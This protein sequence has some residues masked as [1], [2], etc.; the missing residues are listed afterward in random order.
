M[1]K[2]L[3]FEDNQLFRTSAEDFLHLH[4]FQVKSL[5]CFDG[6]NS[7]VANDLPDIVVCDLILPGAGGIQILGHF[8]SNPLTMH[9]PFLFI[10][11]K[12]DRATIRGAM[13]AGADDYV[14][15]PVTA[16]EF[17]GAIRSRL[18]RATE[19]KSRSTTVSSVGPALDPALDGDL[20]DDNSEVF[21]RLSRRELEVLK[22]LVEGRSN[23][24]ISKAM[25][26]ALSTVKRHML[27]IFVKLEVES[28]AVAIVKAHRNIGELN[29]RLKAYQ[30]LSGSGG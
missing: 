7:I 8:R 28:R 21:G 11:A 15:K 14:Q 23:K 1:Q 24:E 20:S 2:V 19:L 22:S 17:L 13:N 4:G 29:R 5:P 9:I 12:D 27:H 6:L 25:F 30:P 18:Q 26:I 3:F 10:S 16:E